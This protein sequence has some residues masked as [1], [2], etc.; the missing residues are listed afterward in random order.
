MAKTNHFVS[1]QARKCRKQYFNATKDAK[2]IALSAQLSKELQETHGIKRLPIHRDDEVQGTIGDRSISGK[3]LEVRLRQMR[4][5]VENCGKVKDN[6][7]HVALPVHPSNLVITKLKMDKHRKELIDKKK[8]G[9]EAALK[10]LG[11]A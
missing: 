7:Q 4:I 5:I 8:A 11:R 10:K 3:V 2:H 1:S 9:R 6:G